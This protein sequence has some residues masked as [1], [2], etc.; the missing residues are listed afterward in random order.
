[1]P[2]SANFL[3]VQGAEDRVVQPKVEGAEGEGTEATNAKEA[4]LAEEQ[5]AAEEKLMKLA[6]EVEGKLF[7][8]F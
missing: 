4:T 7:S 2:L 6:A 1:M 8:A 5:V 3:Q